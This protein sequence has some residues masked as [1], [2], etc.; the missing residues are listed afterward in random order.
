MDRLQNKSL[1]Y[2][3]T[4][5]VGS[6][7]IIL[8][9][10]LVIGFTKAWLWLHPFEVGVMCSSL[11]IFGL[12]RCLKNNNYRGAVA[13][14]ILFIIGAVAIFFSLVEHP[15][16]DWRGFPPICKNYFDQFDPGSNCVVPQE[17]PVMTRKE[18]ERQ[19]GI[20]K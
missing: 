2:C 1:T 13:P 10:S 5:I 11:A 12:N 7:A 8:A 18:F 19:G 9:I 16:D 14:I 20:Y 4:Y 17:L 3:V 6:C 15:T